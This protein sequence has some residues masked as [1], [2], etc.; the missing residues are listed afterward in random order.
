[1]ADSW[2]PIPAFDGYE[3][4][5]RGNVRSWRGMGRVPK[6]PQKPK[7]MMPFLQSGYLYVR[8]RRHGR[9]CNIAVDKALQEAWGVE[10]R[11]FRAGTMPLSA[12]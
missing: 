5:R 3:I 4:D 12:R 9:Y 7:H 6:R 2:R 8:L 1:M 10:R 11:A